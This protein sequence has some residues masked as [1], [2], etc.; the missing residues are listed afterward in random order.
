MVMI[1]R[2]LLMAGLVLLLAG[3]K[4]DMEISKEQGVRLVQEQII[5]ELWLNQYPADKIQIEDAVY[6]AGLTDHSAR[7]SIKIDSSIDLNQHVKDY[8]VSKSG[9]FEWKSVKDESGRVLKYQANVL[10]GSIQVEE[11]TDDHR[12]SGRSMASYVIDLEEH[13]V[14][15]KENSY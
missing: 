9:S 14:T 11:F 1:S 12:G 7:A 8:P 3:C 2:S 10:S 13:T 15:Y 6:Y 5:P 4:D